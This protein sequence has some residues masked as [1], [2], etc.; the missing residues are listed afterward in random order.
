MVPDWCTIDIDRRVLPG[1]QVPAL[2]ADVKGFIQSRVDFDFDMQPPTTM[3]LY[4]DDTNNGLFAETLG[5]S[6]DAVLG[7]HQV[8]GVAYTTHAPRFAATGM[9]TVVFG[10]GSIEQAH[11]K[12]EWIATEQLEKATQILLHFLTHLTPTSR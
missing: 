1:E 7:S 8:V 6:I 4:L 2:L 9:P 10:P 11:T 3:G 12:D 5:Q